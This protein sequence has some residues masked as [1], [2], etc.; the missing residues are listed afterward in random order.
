MNTRLKIGSFVAIIAV[1]AMAVAALD[2]LSVKRMAK[3]GTVLKFKMT[4][5]VDFS[6]MPVTVTATTQEKV[7]KVDD[8][9]NYTLEQT[10]LDGKVSINGQDQDIPNSGPVVTVYK[11]NGEI[12]TI[13]GDSATPDAYRMAMLGILVDPGKPLNPGDTWSYDIKGDSKTG[14]VAGTANFKIVDVEK[15]GD[16]DAVKVHGT[17][18]ETGGSDAA[19]AD[20]DEWIDKNDGSMIKYEGAWT[21]APFPGAPAPLNAKIK[22]TK[23][24]A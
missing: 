19:S 5:E 12:T 10:Q 22:L 23:I 20:W 6:G 7:L 24:T 8:T 13:Q 1:S 21:N 17:I 4:G 16:E 9:G 2:G 11:P 15:V 3:E 14:V 18:K